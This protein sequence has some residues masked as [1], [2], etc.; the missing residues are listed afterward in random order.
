ML[1]PL[2]HR[3]VIKPET[4]E[5]FSPEH[6]RAKQIGIIIATVEDTK[7]AEA[8]V[9]RGVVVAIGPTAFKDFGVES[10]VK[11]GD[12]VNYAKFAG[13]VVT[14]G[15]EKFILLNDEDLICLIKE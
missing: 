12:S 14:E 11:V 7:R 13:K 6:Q 5:E 8:S 15:D 9:D 4:L 10:P 2:L 3:V 1:I